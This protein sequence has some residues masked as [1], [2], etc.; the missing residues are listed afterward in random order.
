MY[1]YWNLTF[2]FPI[3]VVLLKTK[4]LPDGAVMFV[5]KSGIARCMGVILGVFDGGDENDILVRGGGFR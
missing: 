4:K 5:P 3:Y 2:I 1:Q